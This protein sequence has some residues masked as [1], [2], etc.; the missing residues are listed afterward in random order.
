MAPAPLAGRPRALVTGASAGIGM[1]FARQL[2]HAGHDLILVARRRDRLEVLAEQL[3]HDAGVQAEVIAA[4]L[5]D[6]DAL[7]EI[8]ARVAADDLLAL[9]VNNAGFGGYRPFASIE[10]KTIDDLIDVHVRAVARL[11]RAVLPGMV[12][13]G[14]G[15]IIN[16]ASLLALSGTLPPEPLP[17]RATYA[18]AKA[19]MVT[20]TQALAGEL[21]GTGVRV[22]VCLPG[23]VDTEFHT[24]QGLDTSKLPP[25]MTA[26]DI[27]TGALAGLARGE[28]MCVPALADAALLDRL[29][30]MQLAVFRAAAMRPKPALAERYRG[31]VS[32]G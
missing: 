13:R 17:H 9:L 19:F 28:V 4:D 14:A 11:T 10:P 31:A 24:L 30:E 1:A 3:R 25:M 20:F 7:A 5:T 15:G 29:A 12:R 26:D 2:A 21:S 18:A 23:R 16:I 27:V 6:A 32:P 22:Q 8:E